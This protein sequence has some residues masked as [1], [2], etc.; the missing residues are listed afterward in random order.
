MIIRPDALG[1]GLAF[2]FL[3]ADRE[4][5]GEPLCWARE[6]SKMDLQR[7]MLSLN[8][9]AV[10]GTREATVSGMYVLPRQMRSFLP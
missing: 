8:T 10:S 2:G 3:G 4:R 1:L 6:E 7:P 9:A 5:E